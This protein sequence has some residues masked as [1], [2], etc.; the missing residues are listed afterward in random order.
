MTKTYFGDISFRMTK[1]LQLSKITTKPFNKWG[2]VNFTL[3]SSWLL[4]PKVELETPVAIDFSNFLLF[5]FLVETKFFC[6]KWLI[7]NL[8]INFQ[9]K[10]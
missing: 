8:N 2:Y 7:F 5:F 1:I 6:E 10:T 3:F 4:T 9:F